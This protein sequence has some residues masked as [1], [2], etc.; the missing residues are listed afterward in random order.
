LDSKFA[1]YRTKNVNPETDAQEIAVIEDFTLTRPMDVFK[2]N[3][4]LRSRGSEV[5]LPEWDMSINHIE[6]YVGA[7]YRNLLNSNLSL[8]INSNIKRFVKENPFGTDKNIT[9]SWAYFMM[10]VA[11]NQMGLPS[12][13]NFDIHGITKDELGLLKKYMNNKLSQEGLGLSSKDKDFLARIEANV[14]LDIFQRAQLN[15]YINNARKKNTISAKEIQEKADN[16][17]Y[18]FRLNNIK[19]LAQGKNINKIGRFNSAYQLM[20]DESVVNFTEKIDRLFGGKILKDAPKE[21]IARDRYISQL[22]QKL[23]ALEG[24]FEMMSLLFHPKTFLTNLY[25]GFTNTITDVGLKPFTDSLKNEWWEDNVWGENTTY[26]IQ[27]SA[28][29][30]TIKKTIRTRRDWEEWQAFI[31]IFEDMLINEAAKDARFQ[32]QGLI[33]P[34]EQAAKRINRL[35]GEKGLRTNKKLKEFDDF[36]DL[37]L[38]E[39]AKEAGVWEALKN[40]GATFMRSSEFLLRSRTWDA[41]YINTRKILGEFGESLPFDSPILIEI[42]NRTVEASQFIYHATQRPNIANTSLGRIMTRFHPYAWNSIGRR[43]K[44]YKGAFADEWSGGHNTQRA[45][46]QL[47]ADLMAL[48]LANIFVASIFDYALSPPMNWMQDSA[49]LLFGDKKARDRAFFSPYP[50]PALAPLTIA[51]PPI[52]RFVL[53]PITAILNNDFEDFQKYTLY[54]YMPFGRFYRDAKKTFNSPAMMGEFMF[55]VPV[56]TMHRIRRKAM[57]SDAEEMPD[58]EQVSE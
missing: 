45:Q 9:E 24:Q 38:M 39:A 15:S 7:Q 3:G 23:N 30:K 4:N 43:I 34:F 6:R 44:T 20:T 16:M 56:H 33:I 58:E 19:D 47:T 12:L 51:T 35:I 32:R 36:A 46:R 11:K 1:G 48:A 14:G 55:G 37:T 42:A 53:N 21:R 40:T 13:R 8:K 27:D 28:T 17:A 54:T 10:D 26:T 52:A 57:Q 31:G 29:G 25:G 49:A 50:H 18:N 2:S 41:A 5:S 22:G